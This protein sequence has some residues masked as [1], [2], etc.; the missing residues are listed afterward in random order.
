MRKTISQVRTVVAVPITSCQVPEKAKSGPG[1]GQITQ[2][3]TISLI[4]YQ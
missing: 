2:M 1:S 3:S 4:D